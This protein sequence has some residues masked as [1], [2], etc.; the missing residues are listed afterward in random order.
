MSVYLV[1]KRG[2]QSERLAVPTHGGLW[3]LLEAV[4]YAAPTV[5]HGGRRDDGFRCTADVSP[6][7]ITIGGRCFLAGQPIRNKTSGRALSVIE[8][9][10]LGKCIELLASAPAEGTSYAA[11]S[12]AM[13]RRREIRDVTLADRVDRSFHGSFR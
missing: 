1:A 13:D 5:E 6:Q 10:P 4:G 7:P 3:R 12:L 2:L 11:Q 8:R 9:G